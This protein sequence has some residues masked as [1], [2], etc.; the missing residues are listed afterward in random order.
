MEIPYQALI[1]RD[2]GVVPEAAQ[3]TER[4]LNDMPGHY[5]DQEAVQRLLEDDPVLYR[6][7]LVQE[8]DSPSRWNTATSVIEPGRVGQEYHMTKGHYHVN[9]DA[10]EVYLTIR[11]KGKLL[12]QTREGDFKAL[13]MSPGHF[14]YIPGEWAH[15]T[16]NVGDEPL[17]FFAVWPEDAGYDYGTIADRGFVKLVLA[18]DGGPRLVENPSYQ[19]EVDA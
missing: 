7:Y 11:G 16:V 15:R 9:R 4:R 5:H 1:E 6:V 2:S 19:P 3:V 13:D 10:P 12:L 8:E 14:N 18:E 17:V